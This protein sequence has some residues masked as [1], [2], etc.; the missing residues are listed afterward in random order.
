MNGFP[1][2]RKWTANHD[3]KWWGTDWKRIHSSCQWRKGGWRCSKDHRKR[4]SSYRKWYGTS[5]NGK[6][7]IGIA[8]FS[9]GS[10]KRQLE[11]VETRS[12]TERFP[13]D[14]RKD[15]QCCLKDDRNRKQFHSE[16]LK[17][18]WNCSKDD[19]KGTDS[20]WNRKKELGID[21]NTI[22]SAP[23]PNETRA[24]PIRKP[25]EQPIQKAKAV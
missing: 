25:S 17:D 11:M 15:D 14:R 20:G 24:D 9:I 2:T 3:W 23:F 10:A 16:V 22:G 21:H 12:E 6:N 1:S 18:D 8:A 4:G 5:G 7:T 19:W 13:S